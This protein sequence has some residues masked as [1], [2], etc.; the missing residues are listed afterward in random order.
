MLGYEMYNIIASLLH[1]ASFRTLSFESSMC[2]T[3][4]L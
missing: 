3:M 1:V 2:I 4:S